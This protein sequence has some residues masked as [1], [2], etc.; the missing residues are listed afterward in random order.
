MGTTKNH[1]WT[2]SY[3]GYPHLPQIPAG[4]TRILFFG[5]RRKKKE[6]RKLGE[7]GRELHVNERKWRANREERKNE[8]RKWKKGNK[9]WNQVKEKGHKE[10]DKRLTLSLMAL[11]ESTATFFKEL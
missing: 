4:D 9:K 11:G 8:D 10:T 1:Q 6:R 7:G 2:G 3:T 5:A